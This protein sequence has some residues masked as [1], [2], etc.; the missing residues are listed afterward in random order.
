MMRTPFPEV[1]D[2]QAGPGITA[3]DFCST[4]IP[5]VRLVGL[6]DDVRVREG[7]NYLDPGTVSRRWAPFR[8]DLGAALL[9]PSG[10]LGRI[11]VVDSASVGEVAYIGFLRMRRRDDRLTPGISRYLL[12]EL[13]FQKQPRRREVGA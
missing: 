7:C 1:I 11:A 2:F 13:D 9:S 4:G 5:L 12:T 8:A 10:S 6:T 3:S